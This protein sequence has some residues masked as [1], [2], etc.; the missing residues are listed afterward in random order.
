[1]SEELELPELHEA[2]L[3]HATLM[4]LFDDLESCTEVLDVL[5]KG[6]ATQRT[7]PGAVPLRGGQEQLL[8]HQTRSLQVRYRYQQA[9]WRDTLTQHAQGWKLVRMQIPQGLVDG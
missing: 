4:A 6:G 2:V 8:T 1:M 9:E 5:V 7:R 3:D